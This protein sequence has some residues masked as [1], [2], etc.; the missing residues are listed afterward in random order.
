MSNRP[1]NLTFLSIISLG[2]GYMML[3]SRTLAVKQKERA[4]GDYSVSVDRSGTWMILV[5]Y[6]WLAHAEDESR[7][8]VD[9]M[10]FLLASFSWAKGSRKTLADLIFSGGGI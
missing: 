2:S 8:V 5:V 7:N 3:K 10:R 9:D 6:S 4:I 1:R